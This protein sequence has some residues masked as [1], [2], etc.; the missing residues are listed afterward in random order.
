MQAKAA[1]AK[2][3]SIFQSCRMDLETIVRF[4][5]IRDYYL[6][7]DYGIEAVTERSR[8]KVVK[9]FRDFVSRSPYYYQI[10]FLDEYRR[11]VV[12]VRV[13]GQDN[14]ISAQ[15]TEAFFQQTRQI[16]KK[17]IY[18]SEITYSA[19]REGF[20]IY[21]V[22]S[23]VNIQ[24]EFVGAVVIDLDYDKV[25][26]LVKAIRVG[27]L[28]HT[29]LVDNLGRTIAHPQFRPYEYNLSKYPYPRLREFV[30]NM[31]AGETGWKAYYY[32]GEKAAAYAPVPAMGWS[33][34]VTIPIKEFKKE[35]EAIRARVLQVVV[36][37]LL[38]AGLAVSILS[39]NL[40]RPVRRLVAATERISSGDLTQEIPVKS[41]DE[42]GTLTRSFNRMVIN[43][44]DI[45]SELVRSEKLISMGRL[46]A[47]VAHEIRNPLN[48]MKG[49]IV[50]LQRRRSEDPLI[51]E[52]THLILEE[53]ERLNQFVTEF[54]YFARQSS[55]NLTPANLN[56]LVRNTLNLFEEK[57][58]EKGIN[59][60]KHLDPS[61]PSLMIDPNQM[62]QVI[63]N[64]LI[65]AC[66]AM[67]EGG[68]LELS[69]EIKRD[70]QGA[71]SSFRSLVKVED[72]G[73]GIPHEHLQNIFDPFFS[74]KET[75]TGLGLPIS[76]GIVESH[77][78]KLKV[79][80]QERKGTKVII[81]LPVMKNDMEQEV[82]SAK[83]KDTGR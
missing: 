33:V 51:Q 40:L 75:G 2:I 25:I 19:S 66:D 30:V 57:F 83:E 4:P 58:R 27:E 23:F 37:T 12:R 36:A 55:P 68:V 71:D 34:A 63:V 62:E 48:A 17:S 82:K 73:A 28:G 47:G 64:L 81:E 78:G 3:N 24:G 31:I 35:A 65:N 44:R 59:V 70:G 11:E 53:I 20:L 72:D 38:L 43:L 39:Y 45:Q 60:I 79:M 1:A 6:A 15:Q 29:F 80:S 32:L 16:D 14:Q 22:K 7:M 13:H 56:E 21:F 8:K 69:T 5:V 9:L 50:Y 77:G 67:A 61:L 46:S 74:T 41:R 18:I 52:Y 54:L 26:D 10:R 49:A 76:L 42:L